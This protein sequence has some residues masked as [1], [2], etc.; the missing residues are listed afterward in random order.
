MTDTTNE[1]PSLSDAHQED[2]H[3]ETEKRDSSTEAAPDP[4]TRESVAPEEDGTAPSG[5]HSRHGQHLTGRNLNRLETNPTLVIVR[6]I[7]QAILYPL[8]V[9]GM[10]VLATYGSEWGVTTGPTGPVDSFR[11]FFDPLYAS[12]I[13]SDNRFLLNVLLWAVIF[14][15]LV[16]LTNRFWVGMGLFGTLALVWMT[17]NRIK[18]TLRH[19]P[20]LATDLRIAGGG[21]AGNVGSFIPPE[22]RPLIWKTAALVAG[23]WICA[24]LV[25]LLLGK[26]RIVWFKKLGI[27]IGVRIIAFLV[28]LLGLVLFSA[29]L[30]TIGSPANQ[31]A[32]AMGDSPIMFDAV[33]DAQQNGPLVSF[34]RLSSTSV[35]TRPKDY[36]QATMTRIEDK[37][38]NAARSIN[39]TRTAKMTDTTVIGVLSESFSDPTRVPG[40][41]IDGGDPMPNIRALKGQ[42]TSGLM[43]SSGYGGGTANLEYQEL[44]GLSTAMFNS[45]TSS[46]YLQIVPHQKMAFSFNQLWNV[47]DFGSTTPPSRRLPPSSPSDQSP[48]ILIQVECTSVGPTSRRSS[49]SGTSTRSMARST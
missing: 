15:I 22:E 35:V 46:P 16:T 44:T 31:L 18:V 43:L 26:G 8:I 1:Q 34:L 5:A 37:Y 9:V 48:S 24:V 40:I 49:S 42:T 25:R 6:R 19:E 7:A 23:V 32:R 2:A 14:L 39:K 20:V 11:D 12:A 29:G 28:P 21:Q 45:S 41:R 30:P 27:H 33:A 36:S 47:A 38:R 13:L 4:T 10:C 17:A 3:S